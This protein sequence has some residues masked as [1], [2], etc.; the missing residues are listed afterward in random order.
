MVA[1]FAICNLDN[2]RHIRIYLFLR[3]RIADYLPLEIEKTHVGHLPFD[4]GEEGRLAFDAC[5]DGK[6]HQR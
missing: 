4:I 6:R 2:S 5:L 1:G 3:F